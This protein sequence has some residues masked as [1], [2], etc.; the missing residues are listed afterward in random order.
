MLNKLGLPLFIRR[1]KRF[2]ILV[3]FLT[4]L[5]FFLESFFYICAFYGFVFVALD[6]VAG[7]G[8]RRERAARVN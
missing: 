6:R 8:R 3:T 2:S 1:F 7:N 5:I 4:L